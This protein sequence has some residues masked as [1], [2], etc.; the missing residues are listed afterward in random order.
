MTSSPSAFNALATWGEDKLGAE[1]ELLFG[2]VTPFSGN[3]ADL[4]DW[5]NYLPTA[6]KWHYVVWVY[7][8]ESKNMTVYVDGEQVKTGNMVLNTAL[9]RI[10]LGARP[11]AV[12]GNN[13]ANEPLNGYLGAFR[14]EM[15]V[16]S[17][18]DVQHNFER[19]MPANDNQLPV[20]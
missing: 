20:N 15:G 4:E 9:S 19:G 14:V 11:T 6:G 16:L 17:T 2:T 5:G 18:A 12:A 3:Y 1:R 8:Q 7:R 13:F 10:M